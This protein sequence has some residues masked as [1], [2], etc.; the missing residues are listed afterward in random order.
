M[1]DSFDKNKE[2]ML[3]IFIFETNQLL[4]QL[5][6]ILLR[7]EQG[8]G[9]SADDINETFRIMHTIKGSSA[10][11]SVSNVCAVSHA[12]EDLFEHIR[13]GQHA[14][15]D[16]VIDI[17]L[18]ALDFIK[19]QIEKLQA[20]GQADDDESSL[21]KAIKR[22]L[23]SLQTGADGSLEEGHSSAD[24]PEESGLHYVGFKA[25]GGTENYQKYIAKIFFEDGCG[26]ENIRAFSFVFSLKHICGELYYRPCTIADDNASAEYI[27]KNGFDIYFSSNLDYSDIKSMFDKILFVKSYELKAT[28]DYKQEIADIE[29]FLESQAAKKTKQTGKTF[30]IKTEPDKNSGQSQVNGPSFINVAT[31]KLDKLLDLVGEIVVAESMLTTNPEI[32]TLK[33]QSFEN[34]VMHFRRLLKELQDSVMF[35]RMV[36]MTDTFKRMYRIVRDMGRKLGKETELVITGSETEVDKNIIAHLADPLMHLI[37]NAMDHGIEQTDERIKLGKPPKGRI[38]ITASNTGGEVTITVEDDGKGLNKDKILKEAKKK[39]LVNKPEEELTDKE[40]YNFILRPGFS[41]KEQVTEFSGRGVGMDVVNENIARIGG[42]MLIDSIEGAGTKVTIRLPLTL[43]II[44]GMKI[45]VGS[46]IYTIPTISVREFFKADEKDI[47]SD[48]SGHEMV[49]LRGTCYPILR[50]HEHFGV[51]TEVTNFSD[52]VMVMIEWNEKAICLF[53]DRLLGEQSVV[54]KPLPAYLSRFSVFQSGI[55]GC[56]ILGDGNISLILDVK[57][58]INHVI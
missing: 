43:A 50:L 57:S 36:P 32:E 41:T 15:S 46:S 39:G 38:A 40:I 31:D 18:S 10:M 22:T 34:A 24:K 28:S 49:M 25:I 14:S 48:T 20:G 52:G 5:E 2:T 51:K 6:Q 7:S 47:I 19:A 58:L 42:E 11:M 17:V 21:I 45:A 33:S 29:E 16:D 27:I 23:K 8:G 1:A 55:G 4:E 30:D 3:D 26:M 44:D 37:R 13:R 9:M 56:T 54:A 12:V 53:C 35:I